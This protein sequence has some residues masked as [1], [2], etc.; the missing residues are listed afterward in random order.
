[1]ASR[2]LLRVVRQ[3]GGLTQRARVWQR[4]RYMSFEEWLGPYSDGMAHAVSDRTVRTVAC[5]ACTEP[6]V[7]P[8]SD[9]RP[10]HLTPGV[11]CQYNLTW[12]NGALRGVMGAGVRIGLA[13]PAVGPAPG[14]TYARRLSLVGGGELLVQMGSHGRGGDLSCEWVVIVEVGDGEVVV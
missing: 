10:C 4:S 9:G 5:M 13:T 2:V 7:A 12:G 14:L 11:P 6:F 3:C 1:M 8:I